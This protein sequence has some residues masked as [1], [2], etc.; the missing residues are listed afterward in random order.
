MCMHGQFGELL[1]ILLVK[2]SIHVLTL[3]DLCRLS[4]RGG[5]QR[6]SSGTCNG[7]FE[8]NDLLLADNTCRICIMA[9]LSAC[10]RCQVFKMKSV[11]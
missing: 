5:A 9:R 7:M 4:T 10:S 2:T 11:G 1:F 3:A 6:I 8:E